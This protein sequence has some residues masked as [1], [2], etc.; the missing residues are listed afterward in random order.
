MCANLLPL[1]LREGVGGGVRG[2]LYSGNAHRRPHRTPH[3]NPLPQ[4]ERRPDPDLQSRPTFN[5]LTLYLFF[6]RRSS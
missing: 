5:P 3:P 4:G 1:P 6:L 2:A